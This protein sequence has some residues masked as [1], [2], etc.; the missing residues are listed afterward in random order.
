MPA[1]SGG[2]F[3]RDSTLTVTGSGTSLT[4]V[5]LDAAENAGNT[6][7]IIVEDSA[8]LG[9]T[10]LLII[11]F[12][13]DGDLTVRTG[14]TASAGNVILGITGSG[15]ALVTGSNSLLST[16][17]LDLGG[18]NSG[19]LGGT[20]TLTVEND[21][22]VQ[23]AGSTNIWTSASRITIDGGTLETD[24]LTNHTGVTATVSIS[25]PNSGT[26]LTVGTAGGSSTFDGL[27]QNA[28]G[29]SGSLKKT[30]TGTFTL[31]GA[32]TYTGGT[33]I[34]GGSIILGHANALQNSTVD[35]QV[36]DG[37][38]ING[39]NATI[40][41]L[42]GTGNLNLGAQTLSVGGNNASTEY[43]GIMSGAGSL[44]KQGTG[45]LTLLGS[46]AYTGNTQ[47]NAGTLRVGTS[48]DAIPDTS[49]VRT[50][51]GATFQ[52]DGVTE[53]IASLLNAAG[54]ISLT[55][56]ATLEL[57]P[58]VLRFFP[59]TITGASD[60]TLAIVGGSIQRLEAANPNFF[61][62]TSITGGE[63]WLN[64]VN[65][66]QNSTVNI[67]VND[68]LNIGG[69]NATIGGL[70]GPGNLNIGAQALTVGANNTSP[71]AY[72]GILSGSGSL[73]KQGTGTL[74]LSGI[75]TYT[76]G[77]TINGGS[78]NANSDV[79]VDG[80]TFARNATANFNL[81]S[82][83]TLTA[84]NNAQIDFTGD[85]DLD[86]GTTFDLQS[87]ADMMVSGALDIARD[88][89][90]GNGTLLVDGAGTSVTTGNPGH[91]W[92]IAGN[93]ADVTFRNSATG[94]LGAIFL[95]E[96]AVA[97]TTAIFN[98]E[99][100]ATVMTNI[101]LV[102]TDG[103]TTTTGTITVDGAGS[104]L[105]QDVASFLTLGHT[106]TGT[107]TLNVT[108]GGTVNTGTGAIT[109]FTTSAIN[110]GTG[111]TGGTLNANGNMV[112]FGEVNLIDG[113]INAGMVSVFGGGAFNFT[114]G[115]LT[116][117][118][119]DGD[120]AQDGGTLVIGSSPGIT[121]VTGA[122]DLNA[123]ALEIELFDNGGGSPV[124]G[125]DFDQ[126]TADTANLGGTLDLV[127]DPNYI[128]SLADAFQII[129]TTSGVVGTFGNVLGAYLGGGLGFDVL[130][131]AN[132]VTI[133]VISVLLGDFDVDGDV[134]GFDFLTWQRGESPN[135]LSQSDLAD[136]EM[137][138]GMVAPLVAASTAVPEP[139][140]CVV[141]LCGM[142][143]MLFRRELF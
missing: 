117:D 99:S 70:T 12:Q 87:G 134:D 48:G 25:D 40:G 62:T 47:I 28:A 137:N 34:D 76:G 130:Y 79:T 60:T 72:S 75:N 128:P 111:A 94:S 84:T 139:A 115:T 101:L 45:I 138:Y 42:A 96:D 135:P 54:A 35:I 102:A 46:N 13:G 8:S 124:A 36:N 89:G 71:P 5:R 64:H 118:N 83:L 30:G 127:V 11:G 16:N 20:G 51:A 114:G 80:A 119:F 120:L 26:A 132:D 66:L 93:T 125:V 41:G 37:L 69:L 97:G 73:T 141:L 92:G 74:T 52:V 1:G 2:G 57:N 24:L 15:D 68:G 50:E 140:T 55:S 17:Q 6:G 58:T 18:Q 7:S 44:T 126:L 3:V 4:G 100:A 136:W 142:M 112:I 9:I 31:T 122:Y 39:L 19:L 88:I 129:S 56:G 59:G 32:N 91:F 67:N 113:T 103:G 85:Y 81:G 33:I 105:T 108:G 10:E 27:I 86:D 121:A 53:R 63:I 82:G 43:S 38:N 116:V 77:T 98:V 14:A 110:V 78:L 107:A 104:S 61:G 29:G 22:L 21:G 143:A 90:S 106:S 133:E 123:G 109:V 131:N 95:A 65:A 49:P 23:V